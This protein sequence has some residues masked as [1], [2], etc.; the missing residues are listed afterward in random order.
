MPE[1]G[2]RNEGARKVEA[3]EFLTDREFMPEALDSNR[4][5]NA[6]KAEAP[7]F[8]T[9]REFMPEAGTLNEDAQKVEALDFLTDHEFFIS[10]WFYQVKVWLCKV[11]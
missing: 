9:D 6:R 1:A 8:L 4:N 10:F 7:D 3:L 11:S 2:K 5:E